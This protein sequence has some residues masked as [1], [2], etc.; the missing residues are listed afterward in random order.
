MYVMMIFALKHGLF[1][2]EKTRV[3]Y[4]PV[5]I[6]KMKNDLGPTILLLELGS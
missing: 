5:A 6:E 3:N 1:T 2:I 4:S